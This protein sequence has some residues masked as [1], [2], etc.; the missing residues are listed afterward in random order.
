MSLLGNY[1]NCF[2]DAKRNY[3]HTVSTT[4]LYG[5]RESLAML[6]EEGLKASWKKH[7]NTSK[8]LHRELEKRGFEF[9]VKNPEHRLVTVTA[10]VLP[11]GVDGNIVVRRTL[12]RYDESI[13]TV[14]L[15][16]NI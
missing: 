9:F 15:H 10:I 2:N 3:N 12:E 14:K 4:L 16:F 5:L 1:W 11:P 13:F 7:L 6:V 8:I